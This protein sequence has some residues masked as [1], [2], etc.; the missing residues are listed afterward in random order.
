VSTNLGVSWNT[1]SAF[2]TE[3]VSPSCPSKTE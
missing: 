3:F 1:A 2:G